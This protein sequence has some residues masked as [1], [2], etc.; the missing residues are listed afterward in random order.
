MK[1][2]NMMAAASTGKVQEPRSFGEVARCIL[3]GTFDRSVLSPQRFSLFVTLR[4][5][6][7]YSLF[8]IF[9]HL[10]LLYTLFRKNN[11]RNKYSRKFFP[12]FKRK[13]ALCACRRTPSPN[14]LVLSLSKSF[15]TLVCF[16]AFRF[17]N[18]PSP[19]DA[20]SPTSWRGR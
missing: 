5:F 8:P 11:R 15:H 17:R 13:V 3:P 9:L 1:N 20:T 18:H 19:R 16:V 14:S 7:L 4:T 6:S 2:C 12:F 10:N